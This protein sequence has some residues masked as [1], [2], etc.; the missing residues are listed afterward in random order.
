MYSLCDPGDAVGMMDVAALHRVSGRTSMHA[1]GGG[2]AAEDL[3]R[4]IGA[5]SIPH[6][7][8]AVVT[9]VTFRMLFSIATGKVPRWEH[10]TDRV[11][12]GPRFPRP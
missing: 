8:I 7:E 4:S 5:G 6:S 10:R 2:Q 9:P 1:T 3:S 12:W 11:A